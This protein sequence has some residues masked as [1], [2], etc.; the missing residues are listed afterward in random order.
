MCQTTN[1]IQFFVV[2]CIQLYTTENEEQ[3][4]LLRSFSKNLGT[5]FVLMRYRTSN[6]LEQNVKA[7]VF[8]SHKH[9]YYNRRSKPRCLLSWYQRKYSLWICSS[10]QSTK[11]PHLW[12]FKNFCSNIYIYIYIY[13]VG[14]EEVV[15]LLFCTCPCD[16]SLA[17]VLYCVVCLTSQSKVV[18]SLFP[19]L[20]FVLDPMLLVCINFC[21]Y[22]MLRTWATF[23]WPTLYI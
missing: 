19:P 5:Y 15:C 12:S 13:R 9:T 7:S 2:C 11:F 17:L 10:K 16:F 8:D 23:S 20:L 3:K 21:I 14:H 6:M 4:G 18:L 22:A 1:G